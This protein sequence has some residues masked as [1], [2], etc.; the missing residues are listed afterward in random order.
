MDDAVL[1]SIE[2]A[3]EHLGARLVMVLGHEKCGVA[4]APGGNSLW[5][6][7]QDG[8]NGGFWTGGLWH[9]VCNRSLLFPVVMACKE[10]GTWRNMSE[11]NKCACRRTFR[12]ETITARHNRDSL[13]HGK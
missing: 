9:T 2:Y 5:G 4:V 11:A 13:E 1:G 7:R 12:P 3:V 8:R 6:F 10:R